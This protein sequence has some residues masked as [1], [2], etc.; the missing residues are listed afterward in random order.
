MFLSW[1]STVSVFVVKWSCY[2]IV[3]FFSPSHSVPVSLSL[4]YTSPPPY[5]HTHRERESKQ[6]S[7]LRD[8]RLEQQLCAFLILL[9]PERTLP[10]VIPGWHSWHAV[11]EGAHT[12][13]SAFSLLSK[14]HWRAQSHWNRMVW[15]RTEAELLCER[16]VRN[17]R[18]QTEPEA[19]SSWAPVSSV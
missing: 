18:D 7:C 11:T 6:T 8:Q 15:L 17:E 1:V 16:M 4:I 10:A 5:T 13:T 19:R 9:P 14:R 3:S 12:F 2:N